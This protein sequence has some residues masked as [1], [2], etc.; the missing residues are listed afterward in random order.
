MLDDILLGY[1]VDWPVN[2]VITEEALRKYAEIFCYLVQVRFAV[3]SLTEVWRFLKVFFFI[4]ILAQVF[5]SFR[6]TCHDN[7][8]HLLIFSSKLIFFWSAHSSH[9]KLVSSYLNLIFLK[10][11]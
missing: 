4:D 9:T 3:F 6:C 8:Y 2:I 10:S 5:D 7:F 11:S 1:K